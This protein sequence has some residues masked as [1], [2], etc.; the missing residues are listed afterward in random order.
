MNKYQEISA[1]YKG[2]STRT[3]KLQ[4]RIQE[5]SEDVLKVENGMHVLFSFNEWINDTLKTQLENI[6]NMALKS[7]FPEKELSFRVMAN[8]NKQG[9]FYDLYIETNNTLT[10]LLDAKGGGVLDVI[11]MCLRLTYLIRMKGK[12]RQFLL[13]DEP[14]K[15]LDGERVNLAIDWLCKITKEFD[16][17]LLIVTHIPS[18]IFTVEDSGNIEVRYAD[19]KSEVYQ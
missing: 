9:V 7:I 8:R 5:I 1:R 4:E 17:Q 12:L 2:L 10:R 18:L 14:F 16:I 3:V 6:T 19:G 11:Q 13:L 15:N